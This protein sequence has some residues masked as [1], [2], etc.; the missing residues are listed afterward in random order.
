MKRRLYRWI[1]RLLAIPLFGLSVWCALWRLVRAGKALRQADHIGVMAE[2]GFGHTVSGP[3]VMRRL[4]HG[5]R[6][7]FIVFERKSHNPSVSLLWSDIQVV[8]LPF[9]WRVEWRGRPHEWDTSTPTRE[10]LAAWLIAALRRAT[11]ADVMTMPELYHRVAQ[12]RPIALPSSRFG[13]G[14]EG[15]WASLLE[16]VPAPPIRLPEPIR[17]DISARLARFASRSTRGQARKLCCLYLRRKGEGSSDNTT[18]RR[19][20]APFDAYLPALELVREAGYLTLV[21]GD[22]PPEARYAAGLDYGVVC[23][24]WLGVDPMAF[25]LFA[26]T[27]AD[28]WIGNMSGGNLPP[29]LNRIP[30]LVVDGFPYGAGVPFACMHYKTVRD[31]AGRLVHYRRLFAEHALDCDL[32]GWTV[33]DNTPE[34]ITEAVRAFLREVQA[35]GP[36]SPGASGDVFP[37]HT[38]ERHVG[39][40]LSTAWLR[41]FEAE[42]GQDGHESSGRVVSAVQVGP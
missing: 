14:W 36:S 16:S 28:L 42:A 20:G 40:R 35:P 5:T 1:H 15:G 13:C 41:L 32:P 24:P 17:Q 37:E 6:L 29:I 18:A 25:A 26:G 19:V 21:T 27:E 33:C 22:R 9:R 30:M 10:R 2:G 34:Q 23:A 31:A 12:P 38:M 4:F 7:V 39:S 8:F 3:D 11:S